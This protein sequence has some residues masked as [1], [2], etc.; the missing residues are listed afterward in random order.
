M[1]LLKQAEK[2]KSREMKEGWIKNDEGWWMNDERWLFEAVKAADKLM[3]RQTDEHTFVIVDWK[4]EDIMKAALMEGGTWPESLFKTTLKEW[5][6]V[7]Q[8]CPSCL[9]WWLCNAAYNSERSRNSK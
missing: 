4:A 1:I 3:N 5:K 2:L 8:W 9:G 6:G 7:G